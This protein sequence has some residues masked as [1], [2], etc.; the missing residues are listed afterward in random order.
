MSLMEI[1][2]EAE[3]AKDAFRIATLYR[4]AIDQ[5]PKVSAA[6]KRQLMALIRD[7]VPGKGDDLPAIERAA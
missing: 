5:T 4:L 2:R 3:E 6:V 1:I 7:A